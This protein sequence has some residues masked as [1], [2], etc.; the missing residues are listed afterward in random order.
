MNHVIFCHEAHIYTMIYIKDIHVS[1]KFYPHKEFTY[2]QILFCRELP[3]PA[4][5]FQLGVTTHAKNYHVPLN[6]LKL[7]L[8]T[9]AKSYL[10]Y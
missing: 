2:T 8:Y 7:L 3:F 4:T 1:I 10:V 5:L 9:E 6:T